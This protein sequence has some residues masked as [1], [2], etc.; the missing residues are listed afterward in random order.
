MCFAPCWACS[1]RQEDFC[2]NVI[3][4]VDRHKCFKWNWLGLCWCLRWSW[5]YVCWQTTNLR[6]RKAQS[7]GIQGDEPQNCLLQGVEA[8]VFPVIST[9]QE[10]LDHS[11]SSMNIQKLLCR[12]HMIFRCWLQSST[13]VELCTKSL[14]PPCPNCSTLQNESVQESKSLK[15]VEISGSKSFRVCWSKFCFQE[16]WCILLD[17]N[18]LVYLLWPWKM[19]IEHARIGSSP[20][21]SQFRRFKFTFCLLQHFNKPVA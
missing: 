1:D 14:A 5:L 18:I 13:K 9:F 8:Q 10:N 6:G 11:N 7:R 17:L 21:V 4:W 3:R 20:T 16:F 2:S 19:K 15:C 12:K